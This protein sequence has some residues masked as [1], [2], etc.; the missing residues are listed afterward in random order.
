MP[1]VAVGRLCGLCL[2]ATCLYSEMFHAAG[3]FQKMQKNNQSILSLQDQRSLSLQ[4]NTKMTCGENQQVGGALQRDITSSPPWP[5]A[6]PPPGAG[7]GAVVA[8]V[9]APRPQLVHPGGAGAGVGCQGALWVLRIPHSTSPPP[10]VCP[11][12]PPPPHSRGTGMSPAPLSRGRHDQTTWRAVH[13]GS[14]RRVPPGR[15]EG[16]RSPQPRACRTG[17]QINWM[18]IRSRSRK[19]DKP[20]SSCALCRSPLVLSR[21]TAQASSRR[22]HGQGRTA[23]VLC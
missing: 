12:P 22:G 20:F 15:R 16:A 13:P 7:A 23:H 6:P 10:V 8:R 9:E 1:P 17:P 18:T 2:P 14:T 21:A 5:R 4:R 19:A 3:A 11:Y